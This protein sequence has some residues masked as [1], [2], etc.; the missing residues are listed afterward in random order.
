MAWLRS[1]SALVLASRLEPFGIVALEAGV[2]RVPVVATN[3]CGVVQRLHPGST[4]G[5]QHDDPGQLATGLVRLLDD[6][7]LRSSLADTLHSSVIKDFTW[8]EIVRKFWA[9]LTMS[10]PPAPKAA[11]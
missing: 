5:V 9:A 6:P 4:I 8:H 3:V 11:R 7:E 2:F 1:A 10:G